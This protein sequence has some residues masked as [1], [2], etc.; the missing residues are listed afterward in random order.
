MSSTMVIWIWIKLYNIYIHKIYSYRGGIDEDLHVSVVVTNTGTLAGKEAVMFFTFDEYRTGVTPDYKRL[1][2]FEK[3]L[4]E[5]N[6]SMVVRKIINEEELRY[7]GPH[8]EK[9][10]INDP[11]MKSWVGVGPETDCRLDNAKDNSLCVKLSSH[12]PTR[13][14]SAACD[15]A[16]KLWIESGCNV[17]HSGIEDMKSCQ[18]LCISIGSSTLP[19]SSIVND[20]WGWSYVNCLESVVW[21]MQQHQPI[22]SI[23]ST[24]D[25]WMMTTF[26]RDI[27]T[28]GVRNEYGQLY[29]STVQQ[30]L[31]SLVTRSIVDGGCTNP[32]SVV[33]LNG[34]LLSSSSTPVS[35]FLIPVLVG[36]IIT[37]ATQYL[38]NQLKN[39]KYTAHRRTG[40]QPRTTSNDEERYS[41]IQF[42]EVRMVT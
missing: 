29:D 14:Y 10:T 33:Q 15:V 23:D 2:A 24:N 26:C 1:R 22:G 34:V 3:I 5:P 40:K 42:T 6:E 17:H 20:G 35:L 27:F 4:L 31:P 37:L 32:F 41:G 7:V 16:C 21:G 13:E 19:S 39:S 18:D 28:S 25:C 11:T 9:H 38:W 12:N 36:C 30:N 8:D